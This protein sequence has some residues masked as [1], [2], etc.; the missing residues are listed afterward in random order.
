MN[1]HPLILLQKLS[2]NFDSSHEE[3]LNIWKN[4]SP[5]QKNPTNQLLIKAL[6]DP[7]YKSMLKHYPNLEELLPSGFFDDQLEPG[8]FPF[9]EKFFCTPIYKILHRYQQIQHHN[10]PYLI[11]LNTGSYSPIHQGHLQLM[12]LAYETLS[13]QYHVL[14][15]YFSPS[16]DNYVSQKYFGTA[17]YHCDARI[18]LCEHFIFQH[19]YLHVDPWE[20]R[21]NDRPINF[22]NVIL[23]FKKIFQQ[24]FPFPIHIAYIFG[25][26]N[27]FFTKAF[28]EQDIAVCFERPGYELSYQQMK[29]DPL[30]CPD[31]HYFIDKKNNIYSSKLIREGSTH[32]L[33]EKIQSLYFQ[34]KNNQFPIYNSFY[35]IRDDSTYCSS[36]FSCNQQQI[37]SFKESL[38]N[39]F[40]QAF[41]PYLSMNILFLNIEKQNQFLNSPY[42]SHKNIINAD[43]WTHHPQEIKLQITRL[44]YLSD[45]QISSQQLIPRLGSD[46]LKKQLSSIHHSLL[47]FVD[48]D[49]A[50]GKTLEIIQNMLPK[51]ITIQEV[52]SLS[53]QSFYE[54]FHQEQSYQFHDI[55]DIRDFLIGSLEGGLTVELPNGDIGKAPYVWPYVSLSHRVK[56][57]HISQKEFSLDIWKI[58][59]T[60]FDSFLFPLTIQNTF[61]GFQKFATSLGFSINMTLSDFC[62]FHIDSIESS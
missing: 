1:S 20:S 47:T 38:K 46:S 54:E 21:Y 15:G 57:P 52:V 50:S 27:A 58:N 14:G 33:S 34:F 16:H 26:D 13:K 8:I 41:Q 35:L 11:L 17:A 42:F 29:K 9:K 12:E 19:P 22:T 45:G 39:I 44:F 40:I 7:Y 61:I 60:F 62:Q 31:K 32:F 24:Y 56:I 6:L 55:V 59:K 25:S 2:L 30:V 3:I 10:K 53:Q 43:L 51:H 49:I 28:M 5:E 18:D 4:L 37:Q 23:R 48:D 36:I